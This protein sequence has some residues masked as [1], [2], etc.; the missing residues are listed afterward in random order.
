VIDQIHELNPFAGATLQ[1]GT[2]IL[3]PLVK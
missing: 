3:V 2:K 1:A